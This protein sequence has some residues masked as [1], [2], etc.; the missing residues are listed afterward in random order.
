MPELPDKYWET[1]WEVTAWNTSIDE[2]FVDCFATEAEADTCAASLREEG[3]A[4]V[5]VCP[6]KP[7]NP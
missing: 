4:D 2:P 5:A 7:T 6:P 1:H 3:F